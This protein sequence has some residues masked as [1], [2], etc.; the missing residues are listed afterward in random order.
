MKL[1]ISITA[2]LFIAFSCKK[3]TIQPSETEDSNEFITTVKIRLE[4]SADVNDTIWATWKDLTPENTQPADTSLAILNVKSNTN[5]KLKVYFWDETKTPAEN[6][7]DEVNELGNEHRIFFFPSSTLSSL[8]TITPTDLDKNPTPLAI[9]LENT[10]SVGNNTATGTLR[11]VLK[12]QPN[13]KDG[14]FAPGSTDADVKFQMN[15]Q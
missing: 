7:T 10:L 11:C 8:L 5:Y 2:I 14:T 4:N 3:K 13:V 6:I 1:L 15:I 9:G 12:H